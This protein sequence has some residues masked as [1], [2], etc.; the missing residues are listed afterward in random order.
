MLLYYS[1]RIRE[2]RKKQAKYRQN[3]TNKSMGMVG[4]IIPWGII[5]LRWQRRKDHNELTVLLTVV[6]FYSIVG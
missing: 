5:V 2:M 6:Q 1:V 4:R 3:V